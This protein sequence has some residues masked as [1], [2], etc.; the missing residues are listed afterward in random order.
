MG[1]GRKYLSKS[2]LVAEVERRFAAMREE[3]EPMVPIVRQRGQWSSTS[4]ARSGSPSTVGSVWVRNC[5]KRART[6]NSRGGTAALRR[7]RRQ[8]ASL[9]SGKPPPETCQLVRAVS[10]APDER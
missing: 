8:H 2:E 6:S 5:A 10:G 4:A 7:L 1:H 9:N 3:R